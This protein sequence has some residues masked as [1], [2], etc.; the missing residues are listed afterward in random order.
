M[1]KKIIKYFVV[2]TIALLIGCGGDEVTSTPSSHSNST[3]TSERNNNYSSCSL[4]DLVDEYERLVDMLDYLDYNDM[5]EFT[6]WMEDMEQ[7]GYDWEDAVDDGS[8]TD[9]EMFD[10]T[11]KMLEIAASIE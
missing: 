2:F 3:S 1:L 6:D 7:W 8:C 11:E 10:A 9:S 5:D 4:Y